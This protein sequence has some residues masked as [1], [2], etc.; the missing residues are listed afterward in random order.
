MTKYEIKY[1]YDTVLQFKSIHPI[2]QWLGLMDGEDDDII[3]KQ[4]RTDLQSYIEKC[5]YIEI[6]I[7]FR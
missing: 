3:L 6:F 1:V 4:I 7:N 2:K 5:K